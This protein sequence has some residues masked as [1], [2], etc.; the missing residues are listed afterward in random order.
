M[1]QTYQSDNVASV[2]L[3]ADASSAFR[4]EYFDEF[5]SRPSFM[6]AQS[7]IQDNDPSGCLDFGDVGSM[8]SNADSFSQRN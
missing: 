4:N 3:G 8:F 5:E 2:A 6:D 7:P 1:D